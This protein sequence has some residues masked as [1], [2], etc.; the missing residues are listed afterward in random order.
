M[1]I[2][3][4]WNEHRLLFP[5]IL[6]LGMSYFTQWNLL[7]EKMANVA[8][9]IGTFLMLAGQI[10][11]TGIS[12][13][14][15]KTTWLVPW[16]SLMIF[17]LNQWDN[18]L[19]GAQLCVFLQIFAFVGCVV[20][21]AKQDSRWFDFWIAAAFGILATF[22][23][24][25][26]M[27]CWPIGLIILGAVLPREK[28]SLWKIF[29]WLLVW[30]IALCFYFYG[31]SKP[32]H[33]PELSFFYRHPFPALQYILMFL[34][35]PLF[36]LNGL[37]AMLA[38]GA[39]ILLFCGLIFELSFRRKVPFKALAPY[40]ALGLYSI[41]AAA[42]AAITRGG[43]DIMQ[44]MVPHY[45]THAYYLW[46]AISVLLFFAMP[47]H[48]KN[49]FPQ[50]C[51]HAPRAKPVLSGLAFALLVLSASASIGGAS[52]FVERSAYLIPA[53]QEVLGLRLNNEKLLGRIF[54]IP[55]SGD[56]TPALQS[57]RKNIARLRDSRLSLFRD[58]GELPRRH[59]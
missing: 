13:G 51:G 28:S 31:Y 23:F 54:P 33:H 16:I 47:G 15:K 1:E 34:G 46:I 56:K 22:S 3:G 36:G 10:R 12:I 4:Q 52:S 18:W 43:F 32:A 58:A 20:F 7:Y 9:A 38:G 6:W 5:A 25:S 57:L 29:F 17:S 30:I 49:A 50:S 41:G 26:G 19:W 11:R 21:L 8:L 14:N 53:Q 37:T 24:G 35:N 2:W 48:E 44:A 42:M 39:G 59:S 27:L 45:I 40:A 55:E